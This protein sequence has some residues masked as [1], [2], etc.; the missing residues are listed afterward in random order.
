MDIL[1]AQVDELLG[2]ISEF[3]ENLGEFFDPDPEAIKS[4]YEVLKLPEKLEIDSELLDTKEKDNDHILRLR[5]KV[6]HA[7]GFLKALLTKNRKAMKEIHRKYPNSFK[8][9]ASQFPNAALPFSVTKREKS[10]R[11]NQLLQ[12]YIESKKNSFSEESTPPIINGWRKTFGGTFKVAIIHYLFNSLN[13]ATHA[14]K[15][16]N[17]FYSG[18]IYIQMEIINFCL[19]RMSELKEHVFEKQYL[20]VE[21]GVLGPAPVVD[22]NPEFNDEQYDEGGTILKRAPRVEDSTPMLVLDRLH[23]LHI[24]YFYRV[25][26]KHFHNNIYDYWRARYEMISNLFQNLCEQNYQKFK[27]LFGMRKC[28]GSDFPMS[29][30]IQKIYNSLIR[31]DVQKIGESSTLWQITSTKEGDLEP[32][33]RPELLPQIIRTLEFLTE[34]IVG[35]CKINQTLMYKYNYYMCSKT[36]H[37]NYKNPDSVGWTLN[38]TILTYLVAMLTSQNK[39]IQEYISQLQDLPDD[40]ETIVLQ[41]KKAY[42][43]L[44]RKGKP[45]PPQKILTSEMLKEAYLSSEDFSENPMVQCS[46]KL[47]EILN[48]LSN[49]SFRIRRFLKDYED[50]FK[51]K[52]GNKALTDRKTM[53]EVEVYGFIRSVYRTIEIMFPEN[54][55]GDS[56]ETKLA[57]NKVYFQRTVKFSHLTSKSIEKFFRE[58]D[59]EDRQSK[60]ISF[61]EKAQV[62]WIEMNENEKAQKRNPILY[63]IFTPSRFVVFRSLNFAL[64]IIINF[65]VGISFSWVPDLNDAEQDVFQARYNWA[66]SL[67]FV[68]VIVS[69]ALNFIFLVGWIV[70]VLKTTYSVEKYEYLEARVQMKKKLRL[71]DFFYV[72]FFKSFLSQTDIQGFILAIISNVLFIF[73]RTPL[74]LVIQLREI[75]S[76]S[77]TARYVIKAITENGR[78]LLITAIIGLFIVYF[79]A[80]ITSEFLR[81]QMEG[82]DSILLKEA[83]GDFTLLSDQDD[84]CEILFPCFLLIL[85]MGTRNSGVASVMKFMGYEGTEWIYIGRFLLDI[86][87]FILINV[88]ILNIVFGIIIDTFA[89]MRDTSQQRGTPFSH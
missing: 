44:F 45:L 64:G 71:L 51:N 19:S 17:W 79:Y 29:R 12:S 1:M 21:A 10:K 56:N 36:Y 43:H 78:Q 76:F 35:S 22:I 62:F 15:K 65:F 53:E 42:V 13:E 54:E 85:N 27:I 3:W 66:R 20:M 73:L 72:L 48:I 39:Q 70:V 74:S 26:Y 77:P 80:L 6:S 67:I 84:F 55:E 8:K 81:F 7:L 18:D 40:M 24:C 14:Q 57:L 5:L 82:S 61:F 32:M 59:L 50:M 88:I 60:F 37:R 68:L 9:L 83:D 31:D 11:Q 86:S 30:E 16:P 41:L 58:V 47:F 87:F 4:K 33:D 52:K 34:L 75:I 46:L 49:K 23:Q 25:M 2:V 63:A 38:S 28:P 69:L 89:E